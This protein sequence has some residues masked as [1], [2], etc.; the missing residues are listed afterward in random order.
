MKRNVYVAMPAYTGS[1]RVETMQALLH[2]FMLLAANGISARLL[3]N[4]GDSILP[5]CRNMFLMDFHTKEEFTDFV[6]LD[7][8]IAWEEGALLRLLLHPVDFVAGV[9]P[10]RQDPPAFPV[11]WI[12]KD[13]EADEKTG[14]IEARGV[15]TGFM[16]LTRRCVD[17][18]MQ[19]YWSLTYQ[20]DGLPGGKAVALFDFQI[21]EGKYWGEDF[22]FCQRWRG[23]GGQVWV[24]PDITFQH[25]G[26]KRFEG[27]LGDWLMAREAEV[28]KVIELPA[29]K[30]VVR[31]KA[32]S[33][34]AA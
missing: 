6:F 11:R 30:P 17:G 21:V 8:D 10:K 1:V 34:S 29:E 5:R 28:T 31:V 27:H 22:V 16:R 15:P 12:E 26:F 2:E 14:L 7:H 3:V 33:T 18:L 19:R 25:I 20:E 4:A 9:Y 13:Y 32:E 24:D 23:M